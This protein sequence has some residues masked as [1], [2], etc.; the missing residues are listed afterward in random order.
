MVVTTVHPG[1]SAAEAGLV[2][3]AT[4]LAL[5]GVPVH[6]GPGLNNELMQFYDL[7]DVVSAV[8]NKKGEAGPR[9]LQLTLLK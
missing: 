7:G 8:I 4:L 9:P 3:G 6:R 2:E 1:S 5:D